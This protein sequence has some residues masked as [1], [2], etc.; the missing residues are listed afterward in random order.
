MSCDSELEPCL[1]HMRKQLQ[2]TCPITDLAWNE[3]KKLFHLKRLSA[4]EDFIQ[5]GEYAQLIAFTVEG[6]LREYFISSNGNE[7][8]KHFV[9]ANSITGS[10]YDLLSQQ[11]SIA[12]IK[13]IKPTLLLCA[14][15]QQ[16][17]DLY[18]RH[19]CLQKMGR[20]QAESLLM[21]KAKR[22]HDFLTLNATQRYLQLITNHND[23]ENTV[24]QYHL[25][26]YLAI[27]PVAL[28]RIKKKTQNINPG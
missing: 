25:A 23:I 14:N 19:D 28:S 9:F 11:P 7:Y 8:N 13:T 16:F 10:L 24:P 4:D 27:T 2:L 17:T 12:G 21:R 6:T 20:L 26:S 5:I 15:Y 22:E 3:M 1:E 18:D